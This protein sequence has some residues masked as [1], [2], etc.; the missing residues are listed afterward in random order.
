MTIAFSALLNMPEPRPQ[1]PIGQ[2]FTFA[3]GM[4][5]RPASEEADAIV[6]FLY[7]FF[8][9]AACYDATWG[10]LLCAAWAV[11]APCVPASVFER[12]LFR[13]S[14]LRKTNPEHSGLQVKTLLLNRRR[15]FGKVNAWDPYYFVD[16]NVFSL[17]M[18]GALYLYLSQGVPHAV[19]ALWFL[20]ALRMRVASTIAGTVDSALLG[21]G[22]KSN[23]RAKDVFANFGGATSTGNEHMHQYAGNV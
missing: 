7:V 18:I 5:W 11:R 21:N 17:F 19:L 3:A 2:N 14:D 13:L 10:T 22:L 4:H 23:Q 9:L 8:A 16:R 15:F 20:V 1:P 12:F 6:Q